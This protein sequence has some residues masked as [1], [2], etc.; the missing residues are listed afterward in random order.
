MIF[1]VV[2]FQLSVPFIVSWFVV[3]I[4]GCVDIRVIEL[5][6]DEGKMPRT[7]YWVWGG[8]TALFLSQWTSSAC[9]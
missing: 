9:W 7:F 1:V 3:G 4:W 5:V 2:F 6:V 8:L